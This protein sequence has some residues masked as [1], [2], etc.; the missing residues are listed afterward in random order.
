MMS[1]DLIELDKKEKEL[2][3]KLHTYLKQNNCE[4]DSIYFKYYK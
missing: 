4:S 2:M 1:E 3:S